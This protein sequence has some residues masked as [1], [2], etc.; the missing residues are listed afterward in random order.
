[1]I[2]KQAFLEIERKQAT[3]W[4]RITDWDSILN[5]EEKKG[6]Q[7]SNKGIKQPKETFN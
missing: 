1:M 5:R 6:K 2:H 4:L 3:D 7:T